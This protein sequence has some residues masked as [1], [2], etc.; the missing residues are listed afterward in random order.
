MIQVVFD[1]EKHRVVEELEVIRHLRRECERKDLFLYHHKLTDKWGV[2]VWLPSKTGRRTFMDL[3]VVNGPA[4]F[5]R[6]CVFTIKQWA[7]GKVYTM[8][9]ALVDVERAEQAK[10]TQQMEFHE[11]A[12]KAKRWLGNRLNHVQRTHPMW[13]VPG[14]KTRMS[15]A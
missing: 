1:N 3:M 11:E 8:K 14:F 2:A 5:D 6:D 4:D 12:R 10:A 13:D 15:P 7:K 9:D